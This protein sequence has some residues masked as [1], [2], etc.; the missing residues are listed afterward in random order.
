MTR[1]KFALIAGAATVIFAAALG[2]W[3]TSRNSSTAVVSPVLRTDKLPLKKRFPFLGEFERC[4]WVSKVENDRSGGFVPGPSSYSIEAYVVLDPAQTEELLSRYR[5]TDSAG[6][7]MPQPA[8][9]LGDGFP[10]IGGAA[11]RSEELERALP[12][13]TT[14]HTGKILLRRFERFI[15]FK[16]VKD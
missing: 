13:L 4:V 8:F 6:V 16:L 11:E 10:R 1:T 5:W 14:F 15:Y 3:L 7:T 9:P 2:F 12:S